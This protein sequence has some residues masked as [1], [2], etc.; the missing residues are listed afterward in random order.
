MSTHVAEGYIEES[1]ASD[2]IFTNCSNSNV[3][4][5]E[6]VIRND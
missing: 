1:V 5:S 6:S 4:V 2:K 3:V